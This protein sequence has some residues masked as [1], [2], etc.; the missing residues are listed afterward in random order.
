MD[1]K[2]TAEWILLDVMTKDVKLES[3]FSDDAEVNY[4]CYSVVVFRGSQYI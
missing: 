2:E 3:F 1:L 4:R